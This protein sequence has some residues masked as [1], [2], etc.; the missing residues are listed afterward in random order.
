MVNAKVKVK[1]PSNYIRKRMK[2]VAGL[3]HTLKKYGQ[4]ND[5]LVDEKG[6]LLDG[7]RRL[8]A[9][10]RRSK[11][12]KVLKIAPKDRL[13]FQLMINLQREELNPIDLGN[14]LKAYK[15]QKKISW[16]FLRFCW[17][18]PHQIVPK[19][20]KKLTGLTG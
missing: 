8:K 5:I 20:K 17:R 18:E 19:K 6:F 10:G 16:V 1:I 2:N 7:K 13:E 14:A 15:K 3:K 11:K 4:V 9:L 12:I